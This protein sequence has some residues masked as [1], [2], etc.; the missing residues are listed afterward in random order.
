MARAVLLL[1]AATTFLGSGL[2]LHSNRGLVRIQ[3]TYKI[4]PTRSRLCAEADEHDGANSQ[5]APS[6]APN[7][8]E[9][10][11]E[12][13]QQVTEKKKEKEN[14]TWGETLINLMN[15]AILGYF[16]GIIAE[17]AFATLKMRRGLP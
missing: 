13:Q 14:D 9:A 2:S 11:A 7:P 1:L 8:L 12:E 10:T 16:L 17:V 6:Q 3:G 4:T 5:T 15:V